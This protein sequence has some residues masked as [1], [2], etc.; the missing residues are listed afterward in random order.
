M[1]LDE[2]AISATLSDYF[3]R[4]GLTPVGK[5]KVFNHSDDASER[6]F[7]VDFAVGP[8]ATKGIRSCAVQ[9][10]DRQRFSEVEEEIDRIINS[11]LVACEFPSEADEIQGWQKRFNPNPMV[12]ISVEVENAKSKYF[13]A[14]AKLN[15]AE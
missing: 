1:S 7:I 15:V 10:E 13:L 9:I 8:V 6:T 12:G 11:L 14:S 5:F 2:K 3:S 4:Q